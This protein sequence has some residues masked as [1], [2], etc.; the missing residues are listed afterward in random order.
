MCFQAKYWTTLWVFVFGYISIIGVSAGA[1]RLWSHRSYKAK[2]PMK[3]ILMILQTAS[4][5]LSIHWWARNHRMHHKYS[6]TDADPHNPKRGF[7]FAHIGWFLVEKHPEYI[8]K[9]SKVDFTDLEQDPIV[10]FQK[11]WYMYLALIFAFI[12]PPLIPYWC[13]GETLWCAWCANIVRCLLIMHITFSI[14][15]SAHRWG[16]RT[17]TKSNS[18]C[19]NVSVAIVT[20]GEGWHNYH[21]AFPWDYRSS[22]FGNYSIS[23]STAFINLCAFLGMAYDLKAATSDMVKQRIT[24]NKSVSKKYKLE[25]Y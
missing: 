14:N 24:E 7:F 3:L 13:W 12:L 10:A 20:F 25:E 8:K 1:H 17:Y 9:L 4:Y 22:E 2:W 21:H 6:D 18:S 19:D 5:E 16:T 11:R 23:I 15:S